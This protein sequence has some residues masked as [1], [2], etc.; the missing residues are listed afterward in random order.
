M[1]RAR[2]HYFVIPFTSYICVL[3]NMITN[4]RIIMGIRLLAPSRVLPT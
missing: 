1:Q 4:V 2:L 3:Q